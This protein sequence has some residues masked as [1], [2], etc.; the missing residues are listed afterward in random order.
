MV[1]EGLLGSVATLNGPLVVII[2]RVPPYL[3]SPGAGPVGSAGVAGSTGSLPGTPGSTSS[4]GAGVGG[5]G[6]AGAAGVGVASSSPQLPIIRVP[7]ITIT[8]ARNKNLF[9]IIEYLLYR[10]NKACFGRYHCMAYHLLRL[11]IIFISINKIAWNNHC[12]HIQTASAIANGRQF[13]CL[14]Y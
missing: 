7:I 9:M 4:V 12:P 8:K 6:V 11:C 13:R 5:A 10:I 1:R 2:L 3:G 14:N